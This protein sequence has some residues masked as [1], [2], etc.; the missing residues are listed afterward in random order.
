LSLGTA[1]NNVVQIDGSGAIIISAAIQN[2]AGVA[3]SLTKTEPGTLTLSHPN[4]YT[5]RT[6][7]KKGALVV[8]NTTGSATGPGAVHVNLGTLEGIGTISSAV[9]VGTGS[10]SGAILLAG[11][12]IP[13]P[14]P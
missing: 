7:I 5:G 13:A 11:N 12:T 1:T 6:T 8:K 10:S 9:T 14:A 2:G 3:C 4:T